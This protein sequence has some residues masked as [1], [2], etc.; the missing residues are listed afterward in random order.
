[1]LFNDVTPRN[2]AIDNTDHNQIVFSDFAFSEFY[3]DALGEPKLR[4]KGKV[5]KDDF[6]L[7]GIVLLDLNDIYTTMDSILEEWEKY[8]MEVS[9]MINRSD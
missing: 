8:G 6:I 5:R 9:L 7:L 1:M 4:E 2:I 3:V